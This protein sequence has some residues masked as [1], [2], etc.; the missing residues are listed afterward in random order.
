MK[1]FG[2]KQLIILTV[3]YLGFTLIDLAM[4]HFTGVH[5]TSPRDFN[6][7]LGLIAVGL[8]ILYGVT[9]LLRTALEPQMLGR[10][11]GLDPLLTLLALYGGYHFI[12]VAGMI[13]FPIGALLVQQVWCGDGNQS[14]A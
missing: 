4:D 2:L 9:A 1:K 8:L 10:Q 5:W 13:L 7:I 3:F 6:N 14:S 12:G 11:M